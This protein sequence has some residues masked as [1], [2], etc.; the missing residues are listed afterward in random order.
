LFSFLPDANLVNLALNKSA[1][2]SATSE[3][4]NASAGRAVDGDKNPHFYKGLSCTHTQYPVTDSPPWWRV[5][6]QNVVGMIES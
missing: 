1:S 2:Q 4:Y 5:D 6:L 3:Q